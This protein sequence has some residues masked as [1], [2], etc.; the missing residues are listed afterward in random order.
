MGGLV[1]ANS[2]TMVLSPRSHRPCAALLALFAFFSL[3]SVM[4]TEA[5]SRKVGIIQELLGEVTVTRDGEV[6]K[7]IDI[8]DAIE[9]FDLI[10]TGAD[11]SLVVAL[12]RACGMSG[13]MAVK[14][15]SAFAVKTELLSGQPVTEGEVLDGSVAVK[16]RKI[17]GDPALRIRTGGAIMGVRGTAF[18]VV[19]SVNDSLLVGCSEGRVVCTGADGEELEAV[20]GQAVESAAGARLRRIPIAVSNLAAFRESWIADEIEAFKANPL[21]ALDQY[22]RSYRRFREQ[23]RSAFAPLASDAT[24]KAWAEE[25]RAGVVP[26]S[27]D[28]AV[29]KQKTALVR[30]LMA[31]R[32]TMFLFERVYYRLDAIRSLVGDTQLRATLPS[33]G[34]VYDFYKEFTAERA[35]LERKAAAYRYALSL[36]AERNEGRLPTPSEDDSGDFFSEKDDF[37]D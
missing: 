2:R 18:D 17:A 4:A 6:L 26:R 37:F 31:L 24:F 29:M 12:D 30:K 5:S 16:V 1:K 22:I 8:G 32:R 13:T 34:T 27:D 25:R 11:G 35:E 9:N 15:K 28:I 21:A 3:A 19:V 10:K 7:N 23:F 20:P 36:F 14:P 33:G